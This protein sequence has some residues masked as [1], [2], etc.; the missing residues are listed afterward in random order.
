MQ[1]TQ[2]SGPLPAELARQATEAAVKRIGE[3]LRDSPVGFEYQQDAATG[4]MLLKIVDRETKQ[5]IRQVPSDEILA[6][7]RALDRYN[8]LI[9]PEKA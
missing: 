3:F 6:I 7:A 2:R 4:R 9:T 5:V 8:S 1:E